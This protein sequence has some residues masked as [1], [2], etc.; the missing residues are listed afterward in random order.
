MSAAQTLTTLSY[1]LGARGLLLQDGFELE[2]MELGGINLNRAKPPKQGAG[3]VDAAFPMLKSGRIIP[4]NG[5]YVGSEQVTARGTLALLRRSVV[6]PN[7][8]I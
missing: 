2:V 4:M 8:A 3:D 5:R 1:I 7:G 6:K